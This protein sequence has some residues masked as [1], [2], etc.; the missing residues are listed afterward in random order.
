MHPTLTVICDGEERQYFLQHGLTIGRDLTNTICIEKY[1]VAPL[2]VRV[3]QDRNDGELYAHALEDSNLIDLPNGQRVWDLLLTPGTV[4][5]VGPAI[6]QCGQFRVKGHVDFAPACAPQPEAEE[7]VETWWQGD[8]RDPMPAIPMDDSEMQFEFDS[9]V[10][11]DAAEQT[12]DGVPLP[13]HDLMQTTSEPFL[14]VSCPRC[15][16]LLLDMREDAKFCPHCGLHLP[17]H[18]PHWAVQPATPPTPLSRITHLLSMVHLAPRPVSDVPLPKR[19]A[20]MAYANALFN[21]GVKYESGWGG[22]RNMPQALRYY[23]KA[24]KLGVPPAVSRLAV[25]KPTEVAD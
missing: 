3:L 1:G 20:L 5:E 21:L 17:A 9:S 18:C 8:P 15:R 16:E 4:F 2:H 24:A 14:R 6:L 7:I 11:A 12:I 10:A 13:S 19:P 22:L 23:E 25:H